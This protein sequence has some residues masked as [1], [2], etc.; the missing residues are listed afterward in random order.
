VTKAIL[1][2]DSDCGFC[3]WSVDRILRWDRGGKLR[4][5]ALQSREAEELLTGMDRERMMASWHL[6]TS[7]G[8]IYSAGDAAKPLLELLP[9]G[10]PL[11][12]LA[13][14]FPPAT[15]AAYRL[16]ARNRDRLGR[17]LGAQACAVDP[18][19]KDSPRSL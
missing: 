16:I 12:L 13:G 10:R 9:R 4:P 18:S 1:L 14:V 11:A 19:S 7:D 6:V 17:A 5:V 15:N 8:R 3:R 2:Y